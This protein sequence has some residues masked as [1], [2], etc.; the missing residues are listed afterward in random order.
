MY[1]YYWMLHI[2]KRFNLSDKKPSGFSHFTNKQ[3]IIQ[4]VIYFFISFVNK[5]QEFVKY[6][7]SE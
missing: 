7:L 1:E 2:N 3:F 6:D 4:I 5:Q